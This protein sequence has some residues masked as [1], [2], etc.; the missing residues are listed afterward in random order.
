MNAEKTHIIIGLLDNDEKDKEL[1]T[2]ITYY[3]DLIQ[4]FKEFQTMCEN[5]TESRLAVKI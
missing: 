4:F 1:F 2:A 5:F 3:F